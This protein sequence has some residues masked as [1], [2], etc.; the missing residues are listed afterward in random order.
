MPKSKMLFSHKKA[1]FLIFLL[2]SLLRHCEFIENESKYEREKGKK[3]PLAQVVQAAWK[4]SV[5][6]EMCD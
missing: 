2:S 6:F 3:K 5:R 1:F 4:T